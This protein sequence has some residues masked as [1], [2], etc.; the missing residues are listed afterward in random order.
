MT[1]TTLGLIT[2][3]TIGLHACNGGG[4][5]TSDGSAGTGSTGNNGSGVA[6]S[7]ATSTAAPTSDTPTSD[8]PTSGNSA[9]GTSNP[10]TSDTATGDT[11]TSDTNTATTSPATSDS[12]GV[13][14]GT[15]T[16]NSTGPSCG[17]CDEPNQECIDNVCT[18]SCQG[19]D[20]DP[21][22]PAQVC[23]VISGDCKD[24]G[25]ACVLDGPS[26]ACG[27][28]SCGPGTVCDGVDTCLP[29]SPCATVTC[30][31]EGAC[32]GSACVCERAKDCTDPAIDLLNGPFNVDIGGIDFA[33]DCTAWMV[34]LRSGPD[35]L[36]RL[37]PDGALTQWTGV[38][39]LNMG[40]VKVL[41]SLT[42]PQLTVPFPIVPK[43]Q[44][45]EHVE[46]LGEVA[47]TYTCCP[48]CG[49]QANPP[50][51]VARLVE[52]D[53]VTP[54]PIVIIAQKT[55]G[56]GPFGSTAADAGPQGLTWGV[57]RVLYVGNSTANGDFNS[58]DLEK[59]SQAVEY[60]FPARVSASAPVSPCTS[61]SA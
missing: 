38:A 26:V 28:G 12:T 17:P 30:T 7:D 55:Q 45:P 50:Q 46:G 36:R 60:K 6:T 44:P 33:D 18:T 9:T 52:E 59:V 56:T 20:P 58:A 34:T 41:R 54:L 39:N 32:W 21:C 10:A 15:D 23:D 19:Q 16:G 57:D 53:M 5:G 48:T 40:E 2:L 61:W 49:C 47:I 3:A 13:G 11:T 24:P 37:K 4:G 31:T 43:P 22:G 51:G 25:D 29:I 35:Y 14:P 8:T 42:I 1:R 27:A